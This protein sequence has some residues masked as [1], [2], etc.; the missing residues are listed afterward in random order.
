ML[1]SLPERGTRPFTI[2]VAEF[3]SSLGGD[4]ARTE[5]FELESLSAVSGLR[6]SDLPSEKRH[7]SSRECPSDC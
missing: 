2:R 4:W 6:S 7:S 1:V 5:A 3:G